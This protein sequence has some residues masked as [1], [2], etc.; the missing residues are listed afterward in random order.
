MT[1]DTSATQAIGAFVPLKGE[2]YISLTTFRKNGEGVATPVWFVEVGN[3]LGLYTGPSSGKVKRLRHTARVT[4]AP[5][6]FRGEATG[7]TIIASAHLV[8]DEAEIQQIAA[9][10]QKKYG[11]QYW[12]LHTLPKVTGIFRRKPKIGMAYIAITPNVA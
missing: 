8:T 5:C 9:A 12:F 3:T 11:F 1:A 2:T 10:L 6:T 7:P 4:L